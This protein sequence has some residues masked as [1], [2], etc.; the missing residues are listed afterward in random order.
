MR[1]ERGFH[2]IELVVVLAISSVLLCLAGP[3][4]LRSAGDL[5]LRLAAG[6]LAAALRSARWQAIRRGANVAVRFWPAADGGATYALYLDG[7]GDGVLNKDIASGVDPLAMPSRR[8]E[9]TGNQ[10]RFGFPKGRRVRDAS[11]RFMD[12][13][14]DPIRFNDSDLA[15]FSPLGTATPGSAYLTDGQ[16]RLVAV[17]VLNRTGKVQVLLYDV[18][19]EKWR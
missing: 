13:L 4:L 18:K 15:S 7:D 17:R 1:N 11:G 10:M 6:E 9:Q 16:N 3:P 2:L 12:R 8:L 19:T 14:D 5:R